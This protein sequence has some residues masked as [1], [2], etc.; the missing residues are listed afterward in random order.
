M[1]ASSPAAGSGMR[2]VQVRTTNFR[3][4]GTCTIDL[5]H[6]FALVVGENNSGKSNLIDAIRLL[7]KPLSGPRKAVGEEDFAHDGRGTPLADWLEIEAMLAGLTG[8][9]A[10]PLLHFLDSAVP[11]TARVRLR[12]TRSSAGQVQTQW[13]G[14]STGGG[15]GFPASFETVTSTYLHP[16]RDAL[17]DLRPGRSSRLGRL[18]QHIARGD[19][20]DY[21]AIQKILEQANEELARVPAIIAAKQGIQQRLDEIAGAWYAQRVD[22][23]FADPVLERVARSI[24]VLAGDQH[25]LELHENGLGYNNILYI[26]TLLAELAVLTGAQQQQPDRLHLLLVEEPEAHLHPQ[27]QD[28][29]MRFLMKEAERQPN[30]QVIATTHSPNFAA[31]AGVE[32]VTV[33]ARPA[34]H[35]QVTAR[36]LGRFGLSPEELGHLRRFLDVTKASLLFAR[37]VVLVEGIAEQLLLPQLAAAL[38]LSLPEAGVSVVNIGGLAFAPFAKL[39]GPDRLPYRC[40]ILS[41]GDPPGGG[42]GSGGQE[43]E[44]SDLSPAARKLVDG[45]EN[46]Q[47]RVFLARVTFEW[48]L[49]RAGNWEVALDAL[50]RVRP[51]K[52]AELRASHAAASPE[53]R[54]DAFLAAVKAYKGRF[55]QEL[56]ALIA[57]GAPV[58][59]PP[60]IAEALRWVTEPARGS[61]TSG[62]VA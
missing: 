5:S 1:T 10:A 50:E 21:E 53:A 11:G 13:F 22:L 43:P 58:Q 36:A 60:Y 23:A 12:A 6:P 8:E 2:L 9:Q 62:V 38:G 47:C 54:A 49:V 17:A 7:F 56:A 28:L 31:S 35:G 45:L 52:A 20:S 33:L 30:L 48:D 18:L 19:G 14:P 44:G 15:D 37:G 34:R 27:L 55:A 29:L 26:A 40:A 42:G 39:F 16:L 51:R 61:T 32:P 25:P 59:V 4:L 46:E 24:R 57:A 3:N 41:D